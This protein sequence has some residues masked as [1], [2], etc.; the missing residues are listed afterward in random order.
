MFKRYKESLLRLPRLKIEPCWAL[1]EK[2][3]KGYSPGDLKADLLSGSVVGLVAIPLAMALAIACDVPPQFGLYTAIIAGV[4]VALF[5]GSS[6]QVT[7]PTAAFVV[8]LLPIVHRFGF[9]GLLIA[10]LMSGIILV[11]MGMARLGQWIQFIPYPVT[12]GFT[13]GI[14]VVI[15]SI[16]LKDFAG[17]QLEHPAE[18]FTSRFIQY[19]NVRGSFS[20]VE[21]CIGI[22]TLMGLFLWP[23]L[24]RKIPAPLVV[25]SVMSLGLVLI[26]KIYPEFNYA[27]VGNRFQTI[28]GGQWVFGVPSSLPSFRWP[29][30]WDG[31]SG[32]HFELGLDTLEA[33]LPSAFAISLLGAIESL[34]SAVV[35][36]GMTGTRHNPDAELVALGLGNIL[37]P[38]FGGVPA[39][40]AIARTATNI[41]YGARSP[42]SAAFHGIFILFVLLLF[43]P[44]VSFLPMASLAALLLFIAYHMAEAKHFGRIVR[45]APGSDVLVLLI[46]FGLTVIFDMVIGVGVGIVLASLLF[47]KRMAT[48][49]SGEILVEGQ[50]QSIPKDLPKGFMVYEIAGPLFFGA[51]QNAIDAVNGVNGDIHTVVFLMKNV[52]AMDVTGLVALEYTIRNLQRHHRKAILVGIQKQPLELLKR[53]ELWQGGNKIPLFRNLHEAL[54]SIED[55]ATPI[56]PY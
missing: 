1:R 50:H 35:A 47:M 3:K 55:S 2:F 29:W 34:L 26:K 16:Q 14:A 9:A 13:T 51:A 5:G 12:T 15:A 36:D 28:V 33:L 45:V 53:S 8:I 43:A 46:C 56:E 4:F 54:A 38:F 23:K 44:Y 25:L 11:G 30:N 32:P 31:I 21:F 42:I 41:R 19:W 10:G 27:N 37:C 52:P 24:N 7:G 20:P 6:F 18:S 17:L 48:V 49:T 40:G 39:T 22:L